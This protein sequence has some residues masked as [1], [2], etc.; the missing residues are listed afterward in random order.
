MTVARSSPWK[1][2]REF[3]LDYAKG[4]AADESNSLLGPIAAE[5]TKAGGYLI[6][7]EAP[8]AGDAPLLQCRTLLLAADRSVVYD[9]KARGID[10]AYGCLMDGGQFAVLHRGRPEI[11]VLKL[12]GQ[13]EGSIDLS[14]FS[15]RPPRLLCWT[16]RKTFLAAFLA[17]PRNLD[18]VELDRDG[19]A[20]WTCVESIATI[21]IPASMQ[22]L[23]DGSLLIADEFHHV[24][25]Q[26]GRDGSS[27]IRW[28]QWHSPSSSFGSLHRPRC[29]QI[30]A[31]G[32][33]LIAD[34]NNGRIL[35]ADGTGRAA[36]LPIKD[37]TLFSPSSARSLRNGSYLICDAGSRCVFELNVRGQVLPQLG[38][39]KVRKRSFSFPRSVQYSGR[40]RYLI[41]NTAQNKIVEFDHAGMRELPV[42]D[43]HGLFWPRAVRKT[44]HKTVLVADGRNARI[45]ELSLRGDELRQLKQSRHN[46]IF[47]TLQDPH[48]VRLLP[49]RNLLIVDSPQGLVFET[50]WNGRAAWAIGLDDGITLRDPHSAQQLPDGRIL[51][52]DTHNNRILFADPR[53]RKLL[54]VPEIRSGRI[55]CELRL[56]R[57]AEAL[58]DGT[59][60]I[61]DTGNNRVLVSDLAF[62]FLDV[63]SSV[64]DSPIPVP[65]SP[66]PHFNFP[67][68]VQPIT[69]DELVVSDHGNHR[70]LHLRRRDTA[71]T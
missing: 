11:S 54:S 1:L 69:R 38:S 39:L 61:A 62:S 32:S 57:Y 68:W 17:G 35:V 51:I 8:A 47:L 9:S 18:I 56:P 36:P 45:L 30:L 4:A 23:H 3:G 46:D 5:R 52:A 41:A 2:V 28:G 34:S 70:I 10:D 44:A 43:Q 19:R 65:D 21:G 58:S 6:V 16:T 20:L 25:W 13:A 59:L 37:R 49:N 53:T 64:P 22:L 48:D 29:A 71:S 26:L 40:S 14:R 50:D 12:S 66:I 7:D 60:V 24:V 67:R 15:R 33:L 42:R 63:L 55:R 27:R 31:N